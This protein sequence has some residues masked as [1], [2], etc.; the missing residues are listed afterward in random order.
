MPAVKRPRTKART[1]ADVAPDA[2]EGAESAVADIT[3]GPAP[4]PTGLRAAK[5]RSQD[6]RELLASPD[7]ATE[8]PKQDVESVRRSVSLRDLRALEVS[9]FAAS[10][11]K[12]GS[13]PTFE[14]AINLPSGHQ[15]VETI[16]FDMTTQLWTAMA[17]DP[18]SPHLEPTS[19][20]SGPSPVESVIRAMTAY[21]DFWAFQHGTPRPPARSTL[22]DQQAMRD[23]SVS[24]MYRATADAYAKAMR[25]IARELVPGNDSVKQ[26]EERAKEARRYGFS[27]VFKYC[28]EAASSHYV[29]YGAKSVRPEDP[30]LALMAE[31]SDAPAHDKGYVDG[32]EAEKVRLTTFLVTLRDRVEDP[33]PLSARADINATLFP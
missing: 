2:S 25:A 28:N 29:N 18:Q 5:H 11:E 26:W 31:G 6:R 20:C 13:Q 9:G 3:A 17:T 4:R 8:K 30:L 14:A 15:R 19:A 27:D 32:L 16:S 1:Q 10:L 21:R 33:L 22:V 7:T 24:G 12:S 23:S